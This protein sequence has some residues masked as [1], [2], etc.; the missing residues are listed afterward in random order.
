MS[1]VNRTASVSRGVSSASAGTTYLL[2]AAAISDANSADFTM[3]HFFSPIK[4]SPCRHGKHFEAEPPTDCPQVRKSA[5]D[6]RKF[7]NRPASYRC[8]PAI[9]LPRNARSCR[10]RRSD[11]W[12]GSRCR[13]RRRRLR[14]R[15]GARRTLG[16][17]IDGHARVLAGAARYRFAGA[18]RHRSA[19]GDARTQGRRSGIDHYRA[20][21]R[22]RPHRRARRRRRRLPGEAV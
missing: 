1:A 21:Y 16:G 3:L 20:R 22:R 12:R 2:N 15:L 18:R 4:A 13:P 5:S 6:V 11:D 9:P 10:R 7:P 8:G 17:A 14:G 19:Q